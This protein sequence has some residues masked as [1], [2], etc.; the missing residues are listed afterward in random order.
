MRRAR[1]AS[2]VR[3]DGGEER[4][5]ACKPWLELGFWATSAASSR[6]CSGTMPQNPSGEIAVERKRW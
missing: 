1:A 3:R 5:A 2:E 4:F 6:T